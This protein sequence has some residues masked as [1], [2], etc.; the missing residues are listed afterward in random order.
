LWINVGVS[1]GSLVKVKREIHARQTVKVKEVSNLEG[2]W[3][4]VRK[5]ET[6]KIKNKKSY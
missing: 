1:G 2:G 6:R 4:D 3:N 5:E